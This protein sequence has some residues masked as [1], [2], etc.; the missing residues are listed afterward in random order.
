MYVHSGEKAHKVESVFMFVL[1]L[2]FTTLEFVFSAEM[3]SFSWNDIAS[4]STK[5]LSKYFSLD[6]HD[7]TNIWLS[8]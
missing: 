1:R 4:I 5:K 8:F 2:Q 6:V 3:A 7:N